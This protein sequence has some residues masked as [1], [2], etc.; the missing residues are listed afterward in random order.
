MDELGV[1][2]S[3]HVLQITH[4]YLRILRTCSTRRKSESLT[5]GIFLFCPPISSDSNTIIIIY[6]DRNLQFLSNHY[7]QK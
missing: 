6:S 2:N 3:E 1:E 7:K 5:L 4:R